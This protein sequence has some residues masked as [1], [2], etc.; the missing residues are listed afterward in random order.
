MP[1]FQ[2]SIRLYPLISIYL[3]KG[4]HISFAPTMTFGGWMKTQNIASL[5]ILSSL[6][7][8]TYYYSKLHDTVKPAI[9]IDTILI[10]LINILSE[11]PEVSLKG[12]P[13]VSPTTFALWVSLPFPP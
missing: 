10:S 13:T 11:G 3:E 2:A 7:L 1:A 12:S 4:E 9:T 6:P 5:C 8:T